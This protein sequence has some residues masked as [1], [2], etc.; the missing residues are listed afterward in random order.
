ML[1]ILPPFLLLPLFL[2]G[3]SPFTINSASKNK[4][5]QNKEI[6]LHTIRWSTTKSP[7][8]TNG[9]AVESGKLTHCWWENT[10]YYWHYLLRNNLAISNNI[11]SAYRQDSAILSL[12]VYYKRVSGMHK[13]I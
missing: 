10:V 8:N 3:H 13:E 5:K 7:Y 1:V 11:K 12:G 6:P 9:R 2:L 4:A